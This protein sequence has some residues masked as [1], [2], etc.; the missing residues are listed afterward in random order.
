MGCVAVLI[1][2]ILNVPSVRSW[3][4]ASPYRATASATLNQI[5]F[6]GIAGATPIASDEV[7]NTCDNP[8]CAVA[9]QALALPT[10][11]TLGE[12]RSTVGGWIQNSVRVSRRF[13]IPFAVIWEPICQRQ[14]TLGPG[15]LGCMSSEKLPGTSPRQVLF[16]SARFADPDAIRT[17]DLGAGTF[18]LD[19][20]SRISEL[21]VAVMSYDIQPR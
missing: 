10:H 7:W 20:T 16:I 9:V 18:E 1:A 21:S 4:A 5:G 11:P 17:T 12:L 3:R 14:L 15:G 19:P 2:V 8:T 13:D 6:P